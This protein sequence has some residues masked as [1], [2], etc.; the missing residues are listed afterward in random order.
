MII[1]DK[2]N[3]LD[4]KKQ[5]FKRAFSWNKYRSEI[6][7]QPKSNNLD[8]LTDPKFRNNRLF[9]LSLKNGDNDPTRNSFD[10]Y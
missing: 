7:T 2:I 3:F 9:I 6:T 10:K 4:N 5:G 8:Y 1:N